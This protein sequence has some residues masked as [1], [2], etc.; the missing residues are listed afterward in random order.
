[1]NRNNENPFFIPYIATEPVWNIP[2]FHIVYEGNTIHSTKQMK[3]HSLFQHHG[4]IWNTS[5]MF[6]I[7]LWRHKK[8]TGCITNFKKL[9][10]SWTHISNLGSKKNTSWFSCNTY[11][12]SIRINVCNSTSNIKLNHVHYEFRMQIKHAIQNHAMKT[13][14]HS[15]HAFWNH[16][17]ILWSNNKKIKSMQCKQTCKFICKS[18]NKKS[19][20]HNRSLQAFH[21]ESRKQ[22][23]QTMQ[24]NAS[25]KNMSIMQSKT[26]EAKNMQLMQ[27]KILKFRLTKACN[28]ISHGDII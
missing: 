9:Q 20:D 25:V 16:A 11:Q 27:T 2:F 21:A 18:S 3:I 28:S 24:S 14:N 7:T 26:Y 10:S 13:S 4:L 22:D 17:M 1:M 8:W 23:M 19:C 6:C 5:W 12:Y 15:H